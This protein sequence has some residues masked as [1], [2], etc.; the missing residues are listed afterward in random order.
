MSRSVF[1]PPALLVAVLLATSASRLHAQ[2]ESLG[3]VST[4]EAA[5]QIAAAATSY[6]ISSGGLTHAQAVAVIQTIVQQAAAAAPNLAPQI[7]QRAIQELSAASQKSVADNKSLPNTTT[8]EQIMP[9]TAAQALTTTEGFKD[10]AAAVTTAAVTGAAQTGIDAPALAKIFSAISTAIIEES[11]TQAAQ[12]AVMEKSGVASATS[13]LPMDNAAN[14]VAVIKEIVTAAVQV[15]TSFG[16]N[17]KEITAAISTG[18]QAA[19][20]SAQ[21]IS[22]T[23]ANKIS[24]TAATETASA[25]ASQVAQQVATQVATQVAK[26]VANEVQN[27]VSNVEQV[28]KQTQ[29]ET[30]QTGQSQQSSAQSTTTAPGGNTTSGGNGSQNSPI[31]PRVIPIPTPT[32]ASNY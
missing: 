14:S 22:A 20:Q 11:A 8:K 29:T 13:S 10:V 15:A 7:A 25:V 21:N 32:P 19:Q 17:A 30:T 23:V 28:S 31:P 2:A 9:A 16:L 26:A 24:G 1:T 4:C 6:A 5:P 27:Q 3:S 12:H 18:S